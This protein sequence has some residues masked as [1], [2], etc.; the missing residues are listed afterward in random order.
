MF[1]TT[2]ANWHGTVYTAEVS[3]SVLGSY[4]QTAAWEWFLACSHY[5]NRSRKFPIAWESNSWSR[6]ISCQGTLS[7][8]ISIGNSVGSS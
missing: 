7:Q 4:K 1:S 2:E 5:Q 3:L 8:F 6:L